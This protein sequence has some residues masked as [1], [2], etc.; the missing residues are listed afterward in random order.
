MPQ[1]LPGI[2]ALVLAAGEGARLGGGKLLLP[3][4]GKPLIRHV[5]DQA[6][7]VPE[8]LSLTVV[9]GHQAP[10]LERVLEEVLRAR[11]PFPLSLVYNPLWREGQ[12][13]S[14]QSGLAALLERPEAERMEG[15]CV[16]LGDQPLIRAKTVSRLCAAHRAAL[17]RDPHHAASAPAYR[18]QRGNPV[19]LSRSLFPRLFALRGDAGARDLLVSP[20]EKVL[21]LPVGDPG[22]LR[23]VDSPEDY[24]ALP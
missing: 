14:L 9:L 17:A 11:A 4:R 21:L 2:A 1:T 7:L 22:V 12:S 20:G 3:W 19:V 13:A 6:F 16:F 24:A 18:R 10:S 15:V 8:F 5:L 23:D